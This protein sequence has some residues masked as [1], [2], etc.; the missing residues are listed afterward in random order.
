MVKIITSCSTDLY[1]HPHSEHRHA[2]KLTAL[3]D[4]NTYT[5]FL[6]N[7]SAMTWRLI[8]FQVQNTDL[9]VK[10]SDAFRV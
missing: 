3:H 1:K 6:A 10:V 7:M 8:T 9:E 5:E 2:K 4:F